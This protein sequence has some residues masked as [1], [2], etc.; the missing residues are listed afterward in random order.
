VE[1]NKVVFN[2]DELNDLVKNMDVDGNGNVDLAEF[3]SAMLKEF[4][5]INV[6]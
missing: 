3:K 1:N 5:K 4:N 6:D 2:N